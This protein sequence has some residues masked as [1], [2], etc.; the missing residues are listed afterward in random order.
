[1]LRGIIYLVVSAFSFAFATVFV[2]L[3][4]AETDIP[5]MEIS[6]F[7]FL[8]GFIVT[9]I[10]V[11]HQRKKL[12][13]ARGMHVYM[14]AVFN[15]IAVILFF[16][17]VEYSSIGKANLLNMTYPVFVF[18]I[19]P[20]I[21][22]EKT[23][24]EYFLYIIMTGAGIY[25][26]MVPEGTELGMNL[27]NRGDVAALLSGI[28]AG[29]AITTLREARKFNDSYVIVFYLM[30]IGTV[31]N[32]IMVI[33]VFI[34]P[35]GISILYIFLCALFSYIGQYYI[36]EGYKHIDAT[37]GALISATRIIFAV[38]LGYFIFSEDVNLRII[39]GSILI[40]ISI[41]GISGFFRYAG[42]RL[43]KNG[44]KERPL[45]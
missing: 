11:L 8:F 13:P 39:T 45:E 15:T 34:I 5:A 1:M 22:N 44:R 21:N 36:T 14:R 37:P 30:L 32:G 4:T 40:M 12:K 10:Y 17:G 31:I 33:P 6:F 23:S 20:F 19:A 7:R 35:R 38:F 27:L 41:T 28:V 26:T 3:V 24:G 25:L 16:I 42:E 18:L 43:N 9:L 2:K 29:F